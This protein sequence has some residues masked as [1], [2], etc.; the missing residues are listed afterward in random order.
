MNDKNISNFIENYL[1]EEFT[2]YSILITGRWGSGKTYFWNEFCEKNLNL[3]FVPNK[4]KIKYK[5]IYI[6]LYGVSN[7]DEVKN[8]ISMQLLPLFL[9]KDL[10]NKFLKA[11]GILTRN[12]ATMALQAFKINYDSLYKGLNEVTVNSN[13]YILCFDDLERIG[14]ELDI[15]KVLGLIN[16]YVEHDKIKTII[17]ANESE[18]YTSNK[19]KKEEYN[20]L[21]EKLIG[22]VVDFQLNDKTI[23]IKIIES[24]DI[25]DFRAFLNKNFDKILK[26]FEVGSNSNIRSLKY[27]INNLQHI[28]KHTGKEIFEKDVYIKYWLPLIFSVSFEFKKGIINSENIKLLYEKSY[29]MHGYGKD[30]KDEAEKKIYDEIMKYYLPFDSIFGHADSICNYIVFGYL[31]SEQ[32]KNDIEWLNPNKNNPIQNIYNFRELG[33]KFNENVIQVIE[34]IETGSIKATDLYLN[35]AK[36]LFYFRENKLISKTYDELEE[37]FFLGINKN[38]ADNTFISEK[39]FDIRTYSTSDWKNKPYE[40]NVERIFNKLMKLE[41]ETKLRNKKEEAE[42]WQNLLENNIEKFIKEHLQFNGVRSIFKHIDPEKLFKIL[43][44]AES[45]T[46][47]LFDG[48]IQHRYLEFSN[49]KE[50]TKNNYRE[51][52]DCLNNLFLKLQQF[53]SNEESKSL[54]VVSLEIF[55]LKSLLES[56]NKFTEIF[57]EEINENE[58]APNIS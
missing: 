3:I 14:K 26:L 23:V 5:P 40:L 17:I 54:D 30:N 49:Y 35:L 15:L 16:S 34:L 42:R 10:E 11:G 20:R 38:E 57:N 24:F 52:F 1:S 53:L 46:I 21:K 12:I 36:F 45:S 9:Q 56:L 37:K 39:P 13:E 4:D 7:I 48:L 43:I 25:G 55:C 41:S 22:R 27:A 44:K 2:E 50:H 29:L 8:Q 47:R 58:T 32:F 28:F 18:I 19:E 33:E 6:S 51:E 31:D